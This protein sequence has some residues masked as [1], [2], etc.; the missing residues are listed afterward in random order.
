MG[1][2]WEHD[3]RLSDAIE[4][5]GSAADWGHR[6]V[7]RAGRRL[8]LEPVH[9]PLH[10]AAR[11]LAVSAEIGISL[12]GRQW[13]G[14]RRIPTLADLDRETQAWDQKMN[15]DRVLIDWRFTPAKARRKIRHRRKHIMRS[16][17]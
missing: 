7:R 1:R 16:Q 17:T 9:S 14:Q 3:K 2:T 11:Q 15:R 6:L 5:Q 4:R 12:L 10:A 13:L 8:D